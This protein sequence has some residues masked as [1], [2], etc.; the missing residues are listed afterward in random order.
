MIFDIVSELILL[1]LLGIA[2]LGII[3]LKARLPVAVA[4]TVVTVIA[5]KA[6]SILPLWLHLILWLLIIAG[7]TLFNVPFLRR[8]WVSRF[9]RLY[10]QR[11]LPHI[12][13]TE[14]EAL[15]A[16][17]TW[18][19]AELFSGKPD[20]NIFLAG[21]K[22]ELNDEEKFFLEETT[23]TLC[24]MIDDWK[25]TTEHYDL[26][27]PVWDFI[28]RNKFFG[29]VIPKQYGGLGFS[30]YAHSCVVQKIASRSVTAAVT[31]MVPNSLGP[32]MLLLEYGTDEQK[33]HYLPRLASGEEIPCFALTSAQSGSDAASMIDTGVVCRGTFVGEEMIGI[34]LNWSK[35]Y[36][37]LA[38]IATVLGIAFHLYDPD[39][40]LSDQQDVGITLA[41]VPSGTPGVEVGDRHMPLNTPFMNGPIRG[42]DVFIPVDWLIGGKK[43]AGQGWRMLMECLAEGRGISLPALAAAAAKFACFNT[44]AYARVRNQFK[45]PI[46]E[47]E[48]VAEPLSRIAGNAYLMEAVRSVTAAAIDTGEKPAVISAIAKYHLTERMRSVIN[49][50]MDV[51]GGAGI[52]IGPRN[53]IAR[54]Y[55]SVPIAITVEGANILTRSMIIF[56]Q[57][58]ARCHP[59]LSKEM[60]AASDT[61]NYTLEDFDEV[62]YGH[63]QSI[64]RNTARCLFL[65]LTNGRLAKYIPSHVQLKN[66][67]RQ[68]SR[69]SAAFAL[70]SDYTLL[71]LKG[72]FKRKEHLSALLGDM[73]SAMYLASST[74]KYFHDNNCL[75]EQIVFVDWAMKECRNCFHA[76]LLNLLENLP[77]GL[78]K[79][80]LRWLIY[81]YGKPNITQNEQ[82]IARVADTVSEASPAR[83]HLIKGMF[84][85]QSADE[86]LAKLE[87]AF[88]KVLAAELPEKKLRRVQREKNIKS[89]NYEHLLDIA[90]TQNI[91]TGEELKIVRQAHRARLEV[92]AV[93]QFNPAYW[94]RSYSVNE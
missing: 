48:G 26:S 71:R 86:P 61:E 82:M 53:H 75:S 94:Q 41:L 79:I 69:M 32:G 58:A 56:G 42:K 70:V 39:G 28:K 68:I 35:R 7:I 37:T 59:W 84:V 12:S 18:W 22:P 93:D 78:L 52:C 62:L 76:A 17:T 73:L 9:V 40:L 90:E 24:S 80:K 85:P 38:P 33:N 16:G 21:R 51:H 23:Q 66:H 67:F 87:D 6:Y 10:M 13:T 43:Y 25:V 65:A 15:E 54:L 83:K 63:I 30:A 14:R 20:W 8:Q 44:G 5:Y 74:L 31:V 60:A 29:M 3:Y 55:Q 36:I 47:F 49:D 45:L 77:G 1:V 88:Y 64:L 4:L 92:I 72:G 19:D 11:R 2:L 27:E 81:P 46:S 50:A 57:G 91:L 89:L 34:R